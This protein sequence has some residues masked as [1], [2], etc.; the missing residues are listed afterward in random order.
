[1]SSFYQYLIGI[2]VGAVLAAAIFFL[3]RYFRRRRLKYSLSM[4]LFLIRIARENPND[5]TQNATSG[6]K[7]FKTEINKTEQLL[8]NLASLK[9]PFVLEVAVPHIGE[10]IHFYLSVPRAHSETAIKQIQGIWNSA[11]VTEE[12]EDYNIFNPNG[13]VAAAY[14]EQKESIALPIRTYA[15]LG[16]DT[17]SSILGGFSKVNSLGEGAALQLVVKP[18]KPKIQKGV[19]GT[20]EALKKGMT[21]E[22]AFG[23]GL[24]AVLKQMGKGM[25]KASENQEKK[26]PEQN[27]KVV[28]EDAAKAV[29]SKLSKPLLLVNA[30]ILTSAPSAFQANDL[31]EGITSGFN[32]L[33]APRRNEIKIVKARNP[34]RLA[35]DF[36]FRNFDPRSAMILNTEEVAS[37]Y[38]LPISS[39]ETPK[40]KWLKA[41]E[42]APPPNLPEKGTLIGYSSFRGQRKNIYITDEDRRRHL[43]VI[44]QTGTGKSTMLGSMMLED[45]KSGKGLCIVDPHGDLAEGGLRHIPKERFEDVIYFN[46]GDLERPVGL[47]MLEYNFDKPEEK[48]FIVNEMLNIFDKLYDLKTTGGPMFE[49]YMRYALLLLMEDM[50]NEEATLVEVPRL[51]TDA[52]YRRRKLDR[53]TNPVVI[54]FWEKEATKAGGE[55]SLAN[56]TPYV[57]SKFNTFIANDYMRPVI[58][59]AKSAFSFRDI[60]D[61]KKILIINLSKGKIGDINANLLGMVF[62][63]KLLFAALSRVDIEDPNMRNDFYLYIDE[64]QNFTTDSIATI[65]SEARK[66]RLNLTVAHQFIAQLTE[67]IRDSVF[68][69]V[70]SI[71]AARVGPQDAEFLVKQFDPVFSQNDLLNIDNLNC[72]MRLL[73]DGQTTRPFNME[74]P[75]SFFD[76]GNKEFAEKLK[77]YSRLKYGQDRDVIEDEIYRR[78]RD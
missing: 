46:P 77:E 67:K 60:M 18:A 59:Q 36:S 39:T 22:A 15:E 21:F 29:E 13:A 64:F 58:G 35:Y 11:S 41:K 26:T 19:R 49:Q 30:R 54:D 53:I 32:Q 4:A 66:Y 43:Y 23:V 12:S 51:F 55:A 76:P 62:V 17:F 37:F 45:I 52:E 7:D 1:M 8:S 38:H 48:T 57:T 28:D 50:P 73:I 47:N 5:K 56:I 25:A 72:H 44:G 6:D 33:S 42:A 3:I 61:N 69:N 10:E 24:W 9:K 14:L 27:Q 70:G 75:T 31:L 34:Q 68:G 16:A 40:V 74:I 2:G 65:F 78:L 71:A 20:L 63:G